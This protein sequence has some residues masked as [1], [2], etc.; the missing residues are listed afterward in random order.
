[1]Q[2]SRQEIVAD[3]IALLRQL[4]DDWDYSGEITEATYLGA[5]MGFES[6]DIVVLGT[7]IQE[8]Y[9]QVMPFTD[10]FA[11]IGQREQRD[12]AISE[13][14]DFVHTHLNAQPVTPRTRRY[15]HESASGVD[16]VGWRDL[17]RARRTDA[18]W[19]DAVPAGLSWRPARV[20]R[21]AR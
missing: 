16:R 8:H 13:W 19:H 9:G 18:G 7:A 17:D 1:M 4:A 14:V 10:F 6:L 20:R 11:E 21:C 12:I 5:D 2:R 15:Q 3:V